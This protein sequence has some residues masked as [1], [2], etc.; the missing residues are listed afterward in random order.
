MQKYPIRRFPILS[1]PPE[2][3]YAVPPEDSGGSRMTTCVLD[4]ADSYVTGVQK[5]DIQIGLRDSL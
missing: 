5:I 4:M 3:L 1:F 2:V